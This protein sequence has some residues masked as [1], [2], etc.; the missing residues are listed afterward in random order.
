MGKFFRDSAVNQQMFGANGFKVCDARSSGTTITGDF[1]AI[2]VL[3]EATV[4]S[5]AIVTTTGDDIANGVPIP[6]GVTIYGDFTS[7][8]LSAGYLVAYNRAE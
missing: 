7:I 2:T 6:A 3:A 1:V 8:K 5:T 4:G